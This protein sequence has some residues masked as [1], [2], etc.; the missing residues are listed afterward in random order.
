MPTPILRLV[1][2]IV[3]LTAIGNDIVT[4][5]PNACTHIFFAG[6]RLRRMFDADREPMTLDAGGGA[7][8][9]GGKNLM[10]T[11]RR[12]KAPDSSTRYA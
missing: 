8:M 9:P 3:A 12:P 1:M 2:V 4:F 10:A 11:P 6:N 7:M 5:W